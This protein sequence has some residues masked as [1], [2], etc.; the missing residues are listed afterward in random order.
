MA[1]EIRTPTVAW[2]AQQLTIGGI[3]LN[4]KLR[5][6]T[7]EGVWVADIFDV[8]GNSILTGVKLTENESINLG[9]YRPNLPSGDFWVLRFE[10]QSDL[11]TRN[12]LGTSFKIVFLTEAE[13]INAGLR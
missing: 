9:Y 11:I 13:S 7:R 12:N 3:T 8:N 1:I 2:S 10:T 5:W 6:M 4:F